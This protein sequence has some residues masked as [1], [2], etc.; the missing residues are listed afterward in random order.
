MKT[1]IV[2]QKLCVHCV[3]RLSFFKQ[4]RGEIYC[5]DLCHQQKSEEALAR[6]KAGLHGN[7][8]HAVCP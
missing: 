7:T 3:R 8:E 1:L 4:L 6:V 5:S 2:T